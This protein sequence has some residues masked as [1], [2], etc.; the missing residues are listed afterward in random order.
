MKSH[1]FITEIWKISQKEY[2]GGAS[3]IKKAAKGELDKIVAA[4]KPLPGGEFNYFLR[5][6][7]DGY[8]RIFIVDPANKV[9][10]GKLSI[11]SPSG[12]PEKVY[13][14]GSIT[15][16]ANYRGRGIAKALYGIVLAI[17]K[18]PLVAGQSQTP[19]GRRNWIS[20]ASIPG[21]EILGYARIADADFGNQVK[22][23]QY[24][25]QQDFVERAMAA[26]A[27]YWGK[28]KID[29]RTGHYFLFPVEQGDGAMK[30]SIDKSFKLYPNWSAH[31]I[32]T[33]MVAKWRGK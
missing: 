21:V 16:D 7:R 14:V 28:G 29:R 20:L 25:K 1:E 2:P 27:E 23:S 13:Q 10:A 18:V 33:G 30:G 9:L 19:G 6:D 22:L 3:D 31:A 4:S 32:E 8:T 24:T 5:T 15:V 11:N 17:M 26:G 12:F